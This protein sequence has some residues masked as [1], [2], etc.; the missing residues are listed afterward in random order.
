MVAFF[1]CL[2]IWSGSCTFL[3]IRGVI[4]DLGNSA[5]LWIWSLV[6]K[7]DFYKQT[8]QFTRI[9]R[10]V[11]PRSGGRSHPKAVNVTAVGLDIRPL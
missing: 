2:I 7:R 8:F 10:G 1:C 4:L 3:S 9:V 6:E 5:N 11:C